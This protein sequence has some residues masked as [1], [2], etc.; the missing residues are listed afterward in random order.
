MK[1]A[2]SQ[3]YRES[4]GRRRVVLAVGIAVAGLWNS[5][6]A[7]S[8]EAQRLR[9]LIVPTEPGG[10]ID[11][12]ARLLAFA[13]APE[14]AQQYVVVNRAGASGNIATA[15]AARAQ[16]DGDTLLVTGAGH[17]TAPRLLANP[18]YDPIGDFSAICRFA[19]ES[20]PNLSQFP[21]FTR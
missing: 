6:P 14:A 12:V 11:S 2:D 20:Q 8:Q 10:G 15:Q 5:G 19:V 21:S 13:S 4:L 3:D 18:G 9:R 16:S 17:L 1:Y 7:W